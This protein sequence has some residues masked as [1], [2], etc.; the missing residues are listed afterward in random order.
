MYNT[1]IK[2][3]GKII[4]YLLETIEKKIPLDEIV[5]LNFKEKNYCI[6]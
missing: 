4:K 6:I 3:A 5:K 1:F 2:P